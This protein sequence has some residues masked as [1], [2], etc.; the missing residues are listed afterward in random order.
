MT[1]VQGYGT[2]V[3][4]DA[5]ASGGKAL[6]V[7]S[8]VSAHAPVKMAT[9]GSEC[10]DYHANRQ[11]QRWGRIGEDPPQRH[12]RG[13]HRASRR[14]SGLPTPYPSPF[15]RAFKTSEW[16]SSTR[17]NATSTLTSRVSMLMGAPHPNLKPFGEHFANRESVGESD[18]EHVPTASPTGTSTRPHADVFAE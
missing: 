5:T 13:W 3:R 17:R 1:S 7:D 9:P 11:H 12:D 18:S 10:H 2:S 16:T 6:R 15:Q 4:S 14:R 8:A